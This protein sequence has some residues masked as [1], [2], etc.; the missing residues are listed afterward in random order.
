M[1]FA[2]P[3]ALFLLLAGPLLWVLFAFELRRRNQK[4]A[5]LGSAGLIDSLVEDFSIRQFWIPRTLWI[6][7]TIFLV[8]GLAGPQWGGETEV[9]PRRGLDVVFAVDVSKSMRARDV[10]PDRLER[11]K[12]E[13]DY[14]IKDLGDNRVGLV[15]FSGAAFVQ[16]PLTNDIEAVRTFVRGLTPEM[17]P[18]GGTMLSEGLRVASK[19][20]PDEDEAA[21]SAGRVLVV[22]TDGE[23]H[24]G[25]L[26]G[27]SKVL[28]DKGVS[29]FLLGVGSGLG[30]PIPIANEGGSVIDYMKD[31]R[32]KTVMTRMSPEVL[33]E[34]A[35]ATGGTFIDGTHDPTMGMAQVK[36]TIDTLEKKD[37]KSRVHKTTVDRSVYPLAL[38]FLLYALAGLL[39]D[40]HRR[41]NDSSTGLD[42]AVGG[43]S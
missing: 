31:R 30:E 15:A 39:I 13:I 19:L 25:G 24:E 10:A 18:Q 40:R 3:W 26:E 6:L 35:D 28:Q 41:R 27:P 7:A 8:F 32:G 5:L 9:L 17:I 33:T 16:C 11:A 14:F 29:L 4:L 34:V 20:F 43:G 2:S 37:F 36:T 22:I 12:A 1:T 42:Q 23:D 38:S 21:R